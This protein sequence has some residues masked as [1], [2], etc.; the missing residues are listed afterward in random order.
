MNQKSNRSIEYD[1][2]IYKNLSVLCKELGVKRSTVENRLKSGLSLD[3]SLHGFRKTILYNGKKYPSLASI[4]ADYEVNYDAVVAGLRKGKTLEEAMETSLTGK[5]RREQ[6]KIDIMYNGKKYENIYKLSKDTGLSLS[7]IKFAIKHDIPIEEALIHPEVLKKNT[8][9]YKGK[10][11]WNLNQLW[12]EL[13]ISSSVFYR[14][15]KEGF[16]LEETID[17]CV[18]VRSTVEC[19][20][21][22]YKNLRELSRTLGI[23]YS[24][25]NYRKKIYPS[26]DETVINAFNNKKSRGAIVIVY[27]GKTYQGAEALARD[28]G[29][30][31]D[32]LRRRIRRGMGTDE[33]IAELLNKKQTK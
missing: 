29:I 9:I 21:V 14:Y 4:T 27:E 8:V 33:A 1:G 7:K 15:L 24:K 25:L 2:K 22:T 16:T 6:N 11:Y 10:I 12:T 13:N 5:R 18:E 28:I 26:M 31:G 20:G 32:M 3:D 23:P 17:R 19:A 30:S